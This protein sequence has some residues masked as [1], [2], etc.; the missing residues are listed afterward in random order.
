MGSVADLI[1]V[2][3]VVLILYLSVVTGVSVVAGEAVHG[4]LVGLGLVSVL[5]AAVVFERVH[6]ERTDV[7]GVAITGLVL[8]YTALEY[9]GVLQNLWF[10]TASALVVLAT[11]GYGAWRDNP[12]DSAEFVEN[13]D[14]VGLHGGVL[15]LLYSLL[16][17]GAP[18]EFIYAP[19][20]PAVLLFFA[21]SLL[22]TTIAYAT[23]SPSVA[24]DELHHRL[25]SVVRG[26]E[27][28]DD[29]EDRE[30]LGRHVRAVA[31]ALTGV[32]LPSR[33]TV[34]EGP[35]PVVLPA[36]DPPVYEADGLEDL[37]SKLEESGIT[38]YAVDG[39]DVLLIKNGTPTR[40]YLAEENRFGHPDALPEGRFKNASVY[41][42]A[43]VFVDAVESV[44][45]MPGADVEGDEWAEDA[46]ER[47]EDVGENVE[48]L[49][50]ESG[51]D[52]ESTTVEGE[53]DTEG[54]DAETSDEDESESESPKIDVGG[55]ELD[56]DEMFEKA[57]EM[58][59]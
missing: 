41:P 55:D 3:G 56:L 8:L 19:V 23:R 5:A 12:S 26:L 6:Y 35:V 57:D 17:A 27:E 32:S 43:Y 33:V 14:I 44:I 42:A 29:E 37:L 21:L 9:V 51:D 34:D 1:T 25:V 10:P 38:G 30:K 24:S 59:D 15:L 47:V 36:S 28:I 52:T 22:V 7:V 20:F 11:S 49:L 58:F 2:K 46:V 18:L 16:L 4:L 40:H 45:P 53:S 39:G 13:L 31:Q 54:S 50:D 48:S